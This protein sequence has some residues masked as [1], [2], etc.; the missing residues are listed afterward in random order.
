MAKISSVTFH[1]V[2]KALEKNSLIS[3]DEMLKYADLPKEVLLEHDRQIDSAKLS[4][5]FKFCVEKS[6]EYTL[7]LKIGSS[8]TYHS[9][10]VLG[11]LMLNAN[12]LKEVI[13]KFDYYQNLISG[14]IKFYLTKNEK[15]YKIAIYINEN[16]IIPVPSYHAEVHLS[17]VLTILNQIIGKT[18]VPDLTY[19]TI[20]SISNKDEYER[21]FGENI[22]LEKSE[23]AIFF[24][25]EKL[26][27]SVN[28]SNPVM[29][30]YFEAQANRIL[31]D[32]KMTSWYS[33]VKREILK[34]IGEDEIRIE[35]IAN[36]FGISS[37]TLQYH[38]KDENKK[39]RDALLSVRM[40]LANHY[41]KN[42]EM[43]FSSIA[44]FLGYSESSSFFRAYKKYYKTT[45]KKYI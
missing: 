12:N 38:L 43:D 11:Y 32:M 3:I 44:F 20:D 30:E 10:G 37:R 9:L 39:F 21:I 27:I 45:P 14:F 2:L 26:N 4:E 28:N 29:L 36:R 18:I 8:I 17:A 41:I 33:K 7:A 35:F 42:T 1:F 16:P 40:Q 31:E 6:G 24:E 15:Y 22:I 5:I 34:T 19:F 23:N 25:T 13:E